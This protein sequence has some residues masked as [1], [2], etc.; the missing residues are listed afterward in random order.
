MR[1][2]A[3]IVDELR[4]TG[5]GALVVGLAGLAATIARRADEPAR[6]VIPFL[7]VALAVGAATTIVG[8]TWLRR[9]IPQAPPPPQGSPMEP[10]GRTRLR[11]ILASVIVAV[12]MVVAVI[13]A[14]GLAAILAGAAAGSGA[15]D[16]RT[17]LWV[18]RVQRDDGVEVLRAAATSPF[19]GSR[20]PVYARPAA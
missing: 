20:R 16:L 6:V 3:P 13:L 9:A 11:C 8:A 1:S 10:A 17:A 19:A 15:T 5:A 2:L 7:V 12:L 18:G 14:P 4:L